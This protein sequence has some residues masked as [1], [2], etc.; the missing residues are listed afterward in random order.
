[1]ATH[2]LAALAMCEGKDMIAALPPAE[3]TMLEE[4]AASTAHSTGLLWRATR[5]Q[6]EIIW[7]GTYHFPH[8]ATEAHLTALM[9]HIK[10]AD[11]VYLEVSNDD[12]ARLEAQIASDPS[13]MFITTG[14]TLPDLLGEADW[15]TYKA[16]MEKRAIPGFM[17]A[18]FK[19][20]WAAIMLGIGPCEARAGALKAKGIDARIGEAAAA[21]GMPSRSLED[22]RLLLTMLDGFPQEDQIDMIRLFLAWSG[23]ADDMAYTL[24]QR[25]LAQQTGLIWAF[26]RK[27][28][29]D[30]GGETAQEDFALM[31]EQLLT[32]R[33]TGWVDLLLREGDG[34]KVFA[35]V[36]AAHLPGDAGVLNL[37]AGE[38]FTITPLSFDSQGGLR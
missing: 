21:N 28:S 1:M 34:K 14:P 11:A 3:R 18:K 17:A 26:S 37:L 35:A 2:P 20:V 24:R 23:N 13:I 31:E 9:P 5:G 27:I 15:A 4:R 29:L 12:Q 10:A 33:N 25:Y 8:E 22:F 30:Y 38:G 19:P 16:A 36:G 32:N 7:F 6:T